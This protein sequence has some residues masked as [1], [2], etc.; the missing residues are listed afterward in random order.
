MPNSEAQFQWIKDHPDGWDG[1]DFF[2]AASEL[3]FGSQDYPENTHRSFWSPASATRLCQDVGFARVVVQP[4]GERATDLCV[5][6][7]KAEDK[8]GQA[9]R[10][11]SVGPGGVSCVLF[12]GHHGKHRGEQS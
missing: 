7:W 8:T 6:A 2:T 9:E 12:R 1:K 11:G 10:C 4:Y 5:E 3:I